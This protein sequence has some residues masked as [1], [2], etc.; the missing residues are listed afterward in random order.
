[1]RSARPSSGASEAASS[2]SPAICPTPTEI[3]HR[4]ERAHQRRHTIATLQFRQSA[5]RDVTATDDEQIFHERIL[6]R[7]PMTH[8]VTIR[9]TGHRFPA[10]DDSTILQS[11]LDAGLVLLRLPRR[12]LRQLQGEGRRWQDRLRPLL[13]KGAHRAGARAGLRA[14]LQAKPLS[15]VAIEARE[16]RKAG[17]ILVRKLPAR[18]QK[19]ERAADDAMIVYLKLRER[20]PDVPSGQ[21]ITSS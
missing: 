5:A 17:D 13:G 2:R 11:A 4:I 7:A 21:Y 6:P 19:L 15:D 9:N 1:M 20:A 16:V 10:Q 12:R 18:V 8:Q 14:L 3:E